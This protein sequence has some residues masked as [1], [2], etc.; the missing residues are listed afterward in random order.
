MEPFVYEWEENGSVSP[1]L[2]KKAADQGF[3]A[4]AMGKG[5][6]LGTKYYPSRKVCGVEI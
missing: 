6:G 5:L 3:L 1:D 2:Y 4:L